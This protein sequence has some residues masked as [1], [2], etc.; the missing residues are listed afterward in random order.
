SYEMIHSNQIYKSN[1]ES[2]YSSLKQVCDSYYSRA[3]LNDSAT[4]IMKRLMNTELTPKFFQMLY[5]NYLIA[6]CVQQGLYAPTHIDDLGRTLNV[7]QDEIALV[8][9]M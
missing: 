9:R 3:R 6:N 1:D 4:G 8:K 7:S 5:R 2:I